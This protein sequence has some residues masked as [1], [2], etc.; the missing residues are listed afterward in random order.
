M[1]ILLKRYH[2]FERVN[3]DNIPDDFD[4]DKFLRSQNDDGYGFLKCYKY[5]LAGR[6]SYDYP[7]GLSQMRKDVIERY[8]EKCV[9]EYLE[10]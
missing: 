1:G 5:A 6:L 8:G 9:K 7:G 10:N 4:E 3:P 2:N